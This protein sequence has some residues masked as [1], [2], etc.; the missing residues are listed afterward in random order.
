MFRGMRDFRHGR[1]VRTRTLSGLLK[2]NAITDGNCPMF[3][4][5]MNN[6][7]MT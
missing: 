7:A 5:M 3:M 2:I 4:T 6:A 1:S